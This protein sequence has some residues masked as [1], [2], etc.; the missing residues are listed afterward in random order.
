MS[1][2]EINDAVRVVM[3][4]DGAPSLANYTRYDSSFTKAVANCIFHRNALIASSIRE[5]K[6][7]ASVKRV[8]PDLSLSLKESD[9]NLVLQERQKSEDGEAI[10]ITVTKP[11]LLA[12]KEQEEI[13]ELVCVG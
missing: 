5:I 9:F 2:T 13:K 3:I 1:V 7:E 6:G 4:Q 10:W 11:E 8:A 12:L